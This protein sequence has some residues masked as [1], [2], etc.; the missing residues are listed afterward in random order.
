LAIGW[1]VEKL[2]RSAIYR[3]YAR[4]LYTTGMP[5]GLR[6]VEHWQRLWAAP[7]TKIGFNR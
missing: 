5:I 3:E 6:A 7:P 2:T 4:L 1:L